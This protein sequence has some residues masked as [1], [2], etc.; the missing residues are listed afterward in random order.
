M[1]YTRESSSQVALQLAFSPMGFFAIGL[2]Y[3]LDV[4]IECAQHALRGA[5]QTTDRSLPRLEFLFCLRK[6]HGNRRHP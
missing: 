4:P 2:E 6:L 3:A 1:A 5:D